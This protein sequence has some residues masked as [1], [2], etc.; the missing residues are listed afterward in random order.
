MT[1]GTYSQPLFCGKFLVSSDTMGI[2]AGD[3]LYCPLLRMDRIFVNLANVLMTFYTDAIINVF[4][5][6]V[7]I[8]TLNPFLTVNCLPV[9]FYR[10]NFWDKD[11]RI[12]KNLKLY[13]TLDK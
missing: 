5:G 7:T 6:Y 9:C 4:L 2:M 11:G 10:R 8:R 1:P 3:T 12:N 13:C